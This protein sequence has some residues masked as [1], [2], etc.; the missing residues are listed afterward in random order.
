[1]SILKKTVAIISGGEG[2]EHDVSVMSAKN[3]K[4]L[5]DRSQYDI[6]DVFIDKDGAWYIRDGEAKT[7]TF[8]TRLGEARGFIYGSHIRGVNVAIPCLHGDLGEDGT[9]QGALTLAGIS[10]VGQDVYASA[11]T[12]DKIYTKFSASA[13]GIPTARFVFFTGESPEVAKKITE[14]KLGYPVIIKPARLGSSHGIETVRCE[15]EFITKYLAATS[16]E[17]RVL[18]ESLIEFD[19]ELECAYLLGSYAPTG[20]VLSGG[21]FYGYRENYGGTTRTEIRPGLF[22]EAERKAEEY[23]RRLVSALGIRALSRID[24]FVTKNEEVYFNEIN[25]FPG[26]TDTSLFPGLTESMG[27]CHGEFI[28]RLIED[29]LS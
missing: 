10:Y 25:A 4:E 9:V 14:E 23:A 24:F 19:H 27:L 15:E 1:M 11:I 20:R 8:P 3:L 21:R 22:P 6:I 16:M 18:V 17:K 28:N 29:A 12:Q 13:L 5:I 2:C 7:P 26:M